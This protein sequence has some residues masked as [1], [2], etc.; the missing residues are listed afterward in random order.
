MMWSMFMMDL[1]LSFPEI[2]PEELF[3]T[4]LESLNE[5]GDSLNRFIRGFTNKFVEDLRGVFKGY[6]EAMVKDVNETDNKKHIYSPSIC[7]STHF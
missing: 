7:S 2:R 5:G 1:R 3:T 4:A 6:D